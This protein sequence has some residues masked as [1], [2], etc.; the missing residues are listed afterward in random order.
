M[1]ADD[2]VLN[3]IT[4]KI[5]DQLINLKGADRIINLRKRKKDKN[6]NLLLSGTV[7]LLGSTYIITTKIIIITE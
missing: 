6:M 7:E 3:N 4:D 1:T 5:A 2:A